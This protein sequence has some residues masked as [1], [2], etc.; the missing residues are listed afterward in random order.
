MKHTEF[1]MDMLEQRLMLAAFENRT[2]R[3][4]A[5]MLLEAAETIKQLRRERAEAKRD[6]E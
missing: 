5:G 6:D 4:L 2:P 1:A 3:R